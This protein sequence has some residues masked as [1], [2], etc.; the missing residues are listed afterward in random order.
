MTTY[1]I[2][3]LDV[4]ELKRL[5]E[6]ALEVSNAMPRLRDLKQVAEYKKGIGFFYDLVT[7]L[8]NIC[9]EDQQEDMKKIAIKL[10]RDAYSCRTGRDSFQQDWDEAYF[11]EPEPLPLPTLKIGEEEIHFADK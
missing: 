1:P 2:R 3:N 10:Q 5:S 11:N 7:T 6:F 4:D 9:G 8:D